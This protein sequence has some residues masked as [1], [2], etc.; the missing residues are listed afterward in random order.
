VTLA[1]TVSTISGQ[2]FRRQR[3]PVFQRHRLLLTGNAW[4]YGG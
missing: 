2:V 4:T 3:V 1:N